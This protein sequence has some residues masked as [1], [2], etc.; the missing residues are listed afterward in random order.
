[1]DAWHFVTTDALDG[2]L[3]GSNLVGAA[4]GAVGEQLLPF[5]P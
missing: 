2:N 1:V 4:Y 5:Y 3:I